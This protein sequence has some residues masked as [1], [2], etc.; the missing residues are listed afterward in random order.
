MEKVIVGS[1]NL[2][3][4]VLDLSALQWLSFHLQWDTGAMWLRNEKDLNKY[5]ST[6]D[7]FE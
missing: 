5:T 2:P 6:Y 7:L 3:A 1:L 4:T